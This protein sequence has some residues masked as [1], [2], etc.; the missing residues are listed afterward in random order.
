MIPFRMDPITHALAGTAIKQLGFKRKAALGVLLISSLAPDIDYVTRFWGIDV[1]LR[2]HRGI[3][4][5]VLALVLVPLVIAL[6]FG[7]RKGFLYYLFISLLGY[8]THLFMDLTNQYGTQ[9]LSPLDWERYSLDLSFI[10]DPYITVGLLLCVILG[11]R[12]RKRAR[13][14][15]A[16]TLVL[17]LSYFGIRYSL[18]NKTEEFLRARLDANTYKMCPLPNDFL[19]WWFVARAGDEFITGFAD[20]FTGRVCTQERY[21]NNLNDPYVVRSKRDRAV[22][23]F[24]SFAKYPYAEVREN[25]GDVVVIWRELAYSFRAGDHFVTRVFF[26]KSGKITKSEFSF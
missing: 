21:V 8:G 20:L 6:I 25:D 3:T 12:I 10:I 7:F 18:H 17:L 5:G 11:W 1:F 26:D 16:V 19:R 4:H 15:A 14:I 2:Y 23:N 22:E 24:L 9:I 13:I